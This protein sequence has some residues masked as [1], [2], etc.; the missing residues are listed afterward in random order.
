MVHR[1][2]YDILQVDV[3]ADERTIKKSY[4]K[5]VRQYHPDKV[6]KKNI[7]KK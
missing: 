2:F 6:K 7:L 1:K 5:L 3:D 4:M